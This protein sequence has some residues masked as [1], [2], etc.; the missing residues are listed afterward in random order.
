L[1]TDNED[2]KADDD[3]D[4]KPSGAAKACKTERAFI[5]VEAFAK[6]YGTNHNLK[7]AFAKCV[8]GTGTTISAPADCWEQLNCDARAVRHAAFPREVSAPALTDNTRRINGHRGGDWGSDGTERKRSSRPGGAHNEG[9]N[10]D[11]RTCSL[12]ALVDRA[13]RSYSSR[14]A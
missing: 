8:S 5:G 10:D 14:A 4:E 1:W 13:L 3:K 2:E 9:P 6:K 12:R 7:N 11:P